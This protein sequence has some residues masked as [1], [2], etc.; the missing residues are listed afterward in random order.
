MEITISPANDKYRQE[1]IALLDAENLPVADL[2]SI[3]DNF[4]IADD[5]G[6]II[7]VAG[8][9]VYNNYGL[10]RSLV[11]S[12]LYRSNN[13]AG[14]LVKAIE[15]KAEVLGLTA[16]YL[17]TETAPGYFTRKGYETITREQVPEAVKA[18]SEFSHVCPVSAIVMKKTLA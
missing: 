3:L 2:P 8:L 5:G 7:G 4:V 14:Q 18:S 9:E 17:L 16:I 11:V 12:K 15:D 6:A 13:I 10:L 1:I